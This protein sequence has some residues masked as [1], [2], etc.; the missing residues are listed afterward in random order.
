MGTKDIFLKLQNRDS[1]MLC[2]EES[3]SLRRPLSKDKFCSNEKHLTHE[4]TGERPPAGK[5]S[6]QIGKT[7][8]ADARGTT[9]PG[10]QN[11]KLVFA[12][13]LQKDH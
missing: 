9:L 3:R 6:A 7:L 8:K 13:P 4:E 10:V 11:R 5:Q 1:V 2:T 12:I